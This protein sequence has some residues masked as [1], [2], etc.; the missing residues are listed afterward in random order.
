L[1][2]QFGPAFGKLRKPVKMALT[3]LAHDP[4]RHVN[5]ARRQLQERIAQHVHAA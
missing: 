5:R 1:L 2:H 4:D 3:P